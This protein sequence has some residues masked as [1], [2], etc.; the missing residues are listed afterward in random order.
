MDQVAHNRMEKTKKR[1]GRPRKQAVEVEPVEVTETTTRTE[2]V[3]PCPRCGARRIDLWEHYS[4]AHGR[5]Y[6]QCRSCG[7]KVSF[8]AR[9]DR[10]LAV[11]V[12]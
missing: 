2:Q 6:K 1:R 10:V 11:I 9:G 7:S 5:A 12:G 3:I 8:E 4:G